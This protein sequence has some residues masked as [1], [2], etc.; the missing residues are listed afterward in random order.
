ML[1]KEETSEMTLNAPSE[2]FSGN[3]DVDEFTAFMETRPHG[4]H[5]ELIEGVAVM[6]APANP[7]HQLIAYNFCSLLNNVFATHSLDLIAYIDIGIRNIGLKNFQ[8]VPDVVVLPG[9]PSYEPYSEHYRLAAEVMSPSN[10]RR[11]ID[12]KLRRYC[13]APENLYAVVIEPCEFLVEIHAR[14]GAWQPMVLKG[15]DDPI[16]MPEFGL[17]CRVGDL[18]RNTPLIPRRRG[19]Q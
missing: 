5:W 10:T 1:P 2:A 17:V 7:V 14:S 13:E 3:M 16:T 15:A 9:I 6:M 12:L 18:Y 11:E 19:V 4:E 8:P